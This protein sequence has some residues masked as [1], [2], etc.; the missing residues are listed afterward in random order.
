MG[1]VFYS[2]RVS[3]PNCLSAQVLPFDLKDLAIKRLQ[4]VALRV[5]TWEA[6]KKNPLLG[7]VTHQ[8][9]KDNI[10]YLQAKD[11]ENLWPDFLE[12]NRE[13]DATRNQDLFKVWPEF[14]PYV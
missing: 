4:A 8:Q 2:H 6:V 14:K 10:N 13:L 3:Y 11:Q 9:I 7:V 1:I 5:D 12:F